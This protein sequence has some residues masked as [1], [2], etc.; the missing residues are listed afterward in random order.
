VL[1]VFHFGPGDEN[2]DLETFTSTRELE[3][4]RHPM[5]DPFKLSF[6]PDC[7]DEA[8]SASGGRADVIPANELAD[9]LDM[10]CHANASGKQDDCPV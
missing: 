9:M 5:A 4:R 10:M 6:C 2:E 1:T 7:P 8:Y 3:N